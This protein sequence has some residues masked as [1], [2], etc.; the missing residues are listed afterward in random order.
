MNNIY[1][2]RT[3]QKYSFM[4]HG[5]FYIKTRK[6]RVYSVAINISLLNNSYAIYYGNLL[7]DLIKWNMGNYSLEHNL[8]QAY[9][10][11]SE[12]THFELQIMSNLSWPLIIIV[13]ILQPK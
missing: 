12:N 7:K 8:L 2:I 10:T 6:Y 9:L 11:S 1:Q 3:G 13:I 5:R 4:I